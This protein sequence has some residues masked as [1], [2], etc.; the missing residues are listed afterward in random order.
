MENNM[1]EEINKIKEEATAQFNKLKD[2]TKDMFKTPIKSGIKL[3]VL[4]LIIKWIY[5]K[6]FR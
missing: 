1:E 5:K 6:L 2:E 4:Y 3:V